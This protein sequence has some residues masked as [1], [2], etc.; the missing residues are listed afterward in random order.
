MKTRK[1]N[2]VKFIFLSI[3]SLVV[4]IDSYAAPFQVDQQTHNQWLKDKFSKQHQNL[5]PIYVVFKIREY[6]L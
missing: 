1:V 2:I 3:T 4:T 5:I 6:Y